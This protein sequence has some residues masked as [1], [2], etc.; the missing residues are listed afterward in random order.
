MLPGLII[1]TSCS[2]SGYWK[3]QKINYAEEIKKK[4]EKMKVNEEDEGENKKEKSIA[5]LY[6]DNAE[7]YKETEIFSFLIFL[8]M[9]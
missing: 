6:N 8:Y 5:E 7:I 9:E 2:Q 1:Q 3:S 4:R